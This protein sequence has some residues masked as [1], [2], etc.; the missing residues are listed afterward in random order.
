MNGLVI[1][2]EG[3]YSREIR[4][5]VLA[6]EAAGVASWRSFLGCIDH[7]GL[8]GDASLLPRIEGLAGAASGLVPLGYSIGIESGNVRRALDGLLSGRDLIPITLVHPMATMGGDNC[9]SDG[10]VLAAGVRITTNVTLGRHVQLQA[11]ATVGHDSVLADYVTVH[12]GATV[13]GDVHIGAATTLGAGANLLP[14]I[15]IGDDV[16][17]HAGAVV[18]ADVPAGAHVGG[19]PAR[20]VPRLDS[21]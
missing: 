6:I 11:N 4:D 17:V 18:I 3:G 2:G 7:D 10:C 12:P 16:L 9:V 19:V 13:S 8:D 15:R 14:G 1:L 21:R 5:I 20:P